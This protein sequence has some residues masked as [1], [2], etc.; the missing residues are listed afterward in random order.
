MKKII[1]LILLL[2]ATAFSQ[3]SYEASEE[4]LETHFEVQHP[5]ITDGDNT[6]RDIEYDLTISL[7]KALIELEIESSFGDG[8]WSKLNKQIFED[9][10]LQMVNDTRAEVSKPNLNVTVLVKLDREFGDDEILFN[11]TY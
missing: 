11:R 2:S 8:G 3:G 7:N 5:V 1:C 6:L 9:V 4:I 10:I